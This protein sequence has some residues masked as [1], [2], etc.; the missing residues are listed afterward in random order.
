MF[1]FR[2][3][4]EFFIWSRHRGCFGF[5]LLSDSVGKVGRASGRP[6]K[7]RYCWVRFCVCVCVWM[8]LCI[9]SP[10]RCLGVVFMRV[11]KIAKSNSWLWHVCPFAWRNWIFD[12]GV[13]LANL[14][15][16]FKFHW[17]LTRITGSLH[18]DVC[19]FVII[20]RWILLRMWNVSDKS[21]TENP[22][23]L[24]MFNKFYPK[25]VP[26]WDNVKKYYTAGQA[27]ADSIIR[28]MRF[29]CWVTKDT[30]T[31]SQYVILFAFPRQQWLHECA[32]IL[33]YIG[34]GTTVCLVSCSSVLSVRAVLVHR[35]MFCLFWGCFTPLL[36]V[37][38]L[39]SFIH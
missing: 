29:A 34:T 10:I 39:C 26:L 18:E 28:S 35:H 13:F 36:N 25:I 8:D 12:I 37:R 24:F 15:R 4:Y 32:S 1:D 20:S 31:P 38:M 30:N 19:T 27:T 5:C 33:R 14:P 17:N 7:F 21:C 16:K 23:T 9:H 6:R 22:N 2:Q 3:G 11:R